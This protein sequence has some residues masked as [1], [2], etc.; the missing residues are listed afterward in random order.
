MKSYH[1]C[2]TFI[3]IDDIGKLVN[4]IN[5]CELSLFGLIDDEYDILEDNKFND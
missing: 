3:F 4:H 5:G 2:E 1:S